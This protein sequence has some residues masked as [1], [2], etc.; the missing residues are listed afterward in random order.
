M[1]LFWVF[2]M[3]FLGNVAAWWFNR[4][5]V[6]AFNRIAVPAFK[7]SRPR[8]VAVGVSFVTFARRP[9]D[10]FRLQSRVCKLYL[11]VS[12]AAFLAYGYLSLRLVHPGEGVGQSHLAAWVT[13][14]I[15]LAWSVGI[16]AWY[17]CQL[18]RRLER[19]RRW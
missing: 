14:A 3:T 4:I 17:E 10:W 6:P 1:E 5:A 16:F 9:V 13:L 15:F 18:G 2:L 8:V 11:L 12:V 19:I 7:W